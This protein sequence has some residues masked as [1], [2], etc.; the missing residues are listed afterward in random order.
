MKTSIDA[1]KIGVC[2][3]STLSTESL[4]TVVI[5]EKPSVARDIARVLEPAERQG[6][7]QARLYRDLARPS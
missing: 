6:C 5:A 3:A 2:T 4:A 7:S 1:K